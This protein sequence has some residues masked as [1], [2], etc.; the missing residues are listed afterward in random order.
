VDL[1]NVRTRWGAHRS[2]LD[3][4]EGT[5]WLGKG[6]KGI[7]VGRIGRKGEET[8]RKANVGRGGEG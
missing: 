4:G 7:V 8:R 5:P 1:L 6:G 3:L 2:L